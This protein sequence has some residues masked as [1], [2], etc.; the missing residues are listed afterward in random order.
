M[1]RDLLKKSGAAGII[2]SAALLTGAGCTGKAALS[3]ASILASTDSGATW[4]ERSLVT[5]GTNRGYELSGA[6][7]T[8]IVFD[9]ANPDIL[10]FGTRQE[11]LFGSNTA[12]QTW[13]QILPGQYISD[14]AL[15]PNERCTLYALTPIRA[16]R[17]AN[18]GKTWTVLLNESRG[19]VGLSVLTIDQRDPRIVYVASTVGDVFKSQDGGETWRTLYRFTGKNIRRLIVDPGTAGTLYLATADGFVYRSANAGATWQDIAK[20][21][22]DAADAARL[23]LAY[24]NFSI[25]SGSRLFYASEDMLF[26]SMNG[27]ST[28]EKIPILIPSGSSKIFA[29][30]PDPNSLSMISYATKTTFYRTNDGGAH[31]IAR[32]ILS[33]SDPAV[34]AIHPLRSGVIFLGMRA[35]MDESAY[36]Y[37]GS[38]D[39]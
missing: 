36:W 35:P 32:P 24:R 34:I 19:R 26:R 37:S 20:P 10:F 12:G 30:R 29:A 39:Y 15:R 18:C 3:N 1:S 23:S 28:W 7:V 2:L 21:M 6:D 5:T 17:T 13:T 31:W 38:P 11:G 8:R 9:T 4:Q 33:A 14:V 22:R 25:F 27:G 16:L